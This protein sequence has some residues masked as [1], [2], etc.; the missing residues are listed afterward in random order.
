MQ[1]EKISLIIADV[2]KRL[3]VN[4]ESKNPHY[5]SLVEDAQ[6]LAKF[7]LQLK[8][9][10]GIIVEIENRHEINGLKE[11]FENIIQELNHTDHE[12][13]K[14]AKELRDKVEDK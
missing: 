13:I 3:G 11:H 14:L 7:Y 1:A 9:M 2:C 8:E 10:L 12:I 5:L 4:Y 6:K